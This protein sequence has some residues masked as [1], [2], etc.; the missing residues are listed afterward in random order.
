MCGCV[1]N[2]KIKKELVSNDEGQ[3]SESQRTGRLLDYDDI[4]VNGDEDKNVTD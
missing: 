2:D 1:N 3:N 4:N